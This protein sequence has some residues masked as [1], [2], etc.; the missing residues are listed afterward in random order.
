MS[1]IVTSRHEAG[2]F[3]PGVAV[4]RA[5]GGSGAAGAV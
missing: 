5:G 2:G 4:D 3:V 1:A